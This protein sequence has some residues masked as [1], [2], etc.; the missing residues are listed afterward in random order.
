MIL[1]FLLIFIFYSIYIFLLFIL[2]FFFFKLKLFLSNYFFKLNILFAYLKI[3][4]QYVFV[5]STTP[6]TVFTYT[7]ILLYRIIVY[8]YQQ[9]I[10][11][12]LYSL[13]II[14][15]K[16]EINPLFQSF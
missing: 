6:I 9:D 8:Y 11:D 10:K 13:E 5:I 2:L 7:F 1:E 3:K 4:I 14:I 12:L 16:Y 15:I